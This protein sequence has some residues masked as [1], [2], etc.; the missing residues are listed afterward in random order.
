M[1]KAQAEREFCSTFI[2]AFRREEARSGFPDWP[3][4]RQAWNDWTDSL[5]RDGRITAK[6]YDSWG[7]PRCVESHKKKRGW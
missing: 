1:T 2:P 7:H 5:Q 3:G 6:Q 4:R